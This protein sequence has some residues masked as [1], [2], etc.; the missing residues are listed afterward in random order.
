ML[1][2]TSRLSAGHA[3]VCKDI[4]GCAVLHGSCETL[5]EPGKPSPFCNCPKSRMRCCTARS[6]S[7]QP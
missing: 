2:Q 5:C 4:A 7:F 6:P 1:R 3:A